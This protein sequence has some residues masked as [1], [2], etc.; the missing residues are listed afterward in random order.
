MHRPL[1]SAGLIAQTNFGNQKNHFR[2]LQINNHFRNKTDKFC[3]SKIVL[4]I[5]L[6]NFRSQKIIS[7]IK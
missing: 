7:E 5:K 3:K 2:I 6:T 1:V 4:A